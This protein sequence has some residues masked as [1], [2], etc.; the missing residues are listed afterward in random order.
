V[1]LT[2]VALKETGE[3]LDWWASYKATMNVEA[4]VQR[5]IS[6]MFNG[7]EGEILRQLEERGFP[8]SAIDQAELKRSL[9]AYS[10]A[11]AD[12]VVEGT[13]MQSEL[14]RK[15][16]LRRA[17]KAG[18]TLAEDLDYTDAFF[19]NLAQ[20]VWEASATTMARVTEEVM[21]L[22][23]DQYSQG[24]GIKEAGRAV[25]Q[26]FSSLKA[27]EAKRIART[28]IN[29]AQNLGTVEY[30][31]AQGVGYVQWW[32]ALDDRVRGNKPRDRSDHVA[33]HGLIAPLQ[34]GQFPNGLAYP[35]D[36]S[37]GISEWVNCRC[38]A[39]AWF[40]P[41]G[42]TAPAGLTYFTEA[43]L[44][45][46]KKPG[47]TPGE[48]GSHENFDAFVHE[49]DDGTVTIY[50]TDPGKNLA[51]PDFPWRPPLDSMKGSISG[52]VDDEGHLW[53]SSLQVRDD[54]QGQ[55]I[56]TGLVKD[57]FRQFPDAADA[58]LA[59]LDDAVGFYQKLGGYFDDL[60]GL[61]DDF[62]TWEVGMKIPRPTEKPLY[63][64]DDWLNAAGNLTEA[65]TEVVRAYTG[66]AYGDMNYA[67]RHADEAV[68]SEVWS[69]IQVLD[70]VIKRSPT[71]VDDLV[72]YRGSGSAFLDGGSAAIDVGDDLVDL[73]FMPASRDEKIARQ[74]AETRYDSI[75]FEIHVPPGTRA[76][77]VESV[78]GIPWE[79]EIVID[80]GSTL[81]V[82]EVVR[83]VEMRYT[84][85]PRRK[86][87]TTRVVC[88]VIQ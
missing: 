22:L 16:V 61:A 70:D 35:G 21:T 29:Y 88:E 48:Y 9:N 86:Y 75:I 81:R 40:M 13:S 38:T 71:T 58:R 45:D 84:Y 1:D 42:K 56:G 18:I 52:Y 65:Q 72:L 14:A 85:D 55:G 19:T 80:R 64:L 34:G 69:K 59:A 6:K 74:F 3:F 11:L 54:A 8:V 33:L 12:V 2:Q 47:Q 26:K 67:L 68:S 24:K 10:E 27:Y 7:I 44:V 28:E 39:V 31:K 17:A 32:T 5:K 30:L 76:I 60:G 78:S 43:D 87:T 46:I 66:V 63:T 25:Q 79:R 77:D 20:H 4:R 57:L 41:P 73:A 51:D 49:S 53:L 37:G 62:E 23:A 36:R 50:A 83:D 15:E 82:T